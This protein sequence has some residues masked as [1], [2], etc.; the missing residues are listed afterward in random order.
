M[1]AVKAQDLAD[2][3]DDL[4]GR[5]TGETV[6]ISLDAIRFSGMVMATCETTRSRDRLVSLSARF[7]GLKLEH[8][9]DDF[10]VVFSAA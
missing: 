4:F 9:A 3:Y 2:K 1:D 10:T 8:C 6:R 7:G 5:I